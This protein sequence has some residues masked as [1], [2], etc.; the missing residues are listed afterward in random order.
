MIFPEPCTAHKG[1]RSNAADKLA[2]SPVTRSVRVSS[3]ALAWDVIPGPSAD[4]VIFEW[5][6]RR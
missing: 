6:R 1:R 5:C 2:P 3:T 4:T